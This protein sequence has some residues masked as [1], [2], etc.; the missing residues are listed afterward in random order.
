MSIFKKLKAHFNI[1]LRNPLELKY[2]IRTI[3]ERISRGVVLKR[4]LP[5]EFNSLPMFVSP[6]GGLKY[7]KTNLNNIDPMLYNVATNFIQ[8]DDVI[9]DIGANIGL[10]TFAAIAK[11]GKNGK[12]LAI[13]ADIVMA[14]L[15][16][17]SAA[18]NREYT[19]DILPLAISNYNGL[20][21]FNIAERARATN[22]LVIA[23]GSNQTGGI[24]DTY[25]VPTVTLDYLLEHYAKPDFLKIDVE[26]AE[27]FV[28]EGATTLM[29]T[30]RPKILVEVGEENEDYITNLFNENKY[31]MYNADDLQN[32]SKIKEATSNTL[33]IPEEKIKN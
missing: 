13:E 26:G 32:F 12:C 11:A 8:K 14:N 7:W 17:R 31:V 27:K 19:I 16:K 22:H 15:V 21:E 18:L 20:V 25:K 5:K 29:E 1:L 28:L 23:Q 3:T 6:E 2:M 9:W 24:R 33:A 10:F 4:N 30:A